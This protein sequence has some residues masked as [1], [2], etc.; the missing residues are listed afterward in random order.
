MK[1]AIMPNGART[2]TFAGLTLALACAGCGASGES[3]PAQASSAAPSRTPVQAPQ[4]P[5][6]PQAADGTSVRACRD[7]NCEVLVTKRMTIPLD[8]RFGFKT[9]SFDPADSTWRYT[10]PDG[11]SGQL[12]FIE[13]PYSGSWAGPTADQQLN[14][15]V[16]ASDGSKAVISLTPGK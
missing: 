8:A 3:P 13:P 12:K 10:Y 6:F 15:K 2:L 1:M 7:G 16:V 14:L 5:G 9:F 4:T 11:G